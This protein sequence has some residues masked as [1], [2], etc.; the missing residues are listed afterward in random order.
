MSTTGNQIQEATIRL[1]AGRYEGRID[2]SPQTQASITNFSLA[3]VFPANPK[4]NYNSTGSADHVLDG[5][6]SVIATDHGYAAA[7]INSATYQVLA[8]LLYQN[9]PTSFMPYSNATTTV[10]L[11][12]SASLAINTPRAYGFFAVPNAN[13]LLYQAEAEAGTMIAPFVSA[14]DAA[15]SGGNAA[16]CPSGSTVASGFRVTVPNSTGVTLPQGT[17]L[18]RARMRA[19]TAT[20]AVVQ[21]RSYIDVAAVSGPFIDLAPNQLATTYAWKTIQTITVGAGGAIVKAYFQSNGAAT[22]TDDWFVDEVVYLPLSL[23]TNNGPQDIYQQF[24][25]YREARKVR[26]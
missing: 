21:W 6:T 4:I 3:L 5:S 1:Q 2:Y 17:Y 18:V 19:T 9:P 23:A 20:S 25:Y 8:G 24:A 16:K 10:G 11:G 13:V 26:G 14:V 22:T 12:D 7:F 15:G